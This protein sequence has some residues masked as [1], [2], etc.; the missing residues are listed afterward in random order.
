MLMK[1]LAL[2]T[3]VSIAGTAAGQNSATAPAKP[4]AQPAK[5]DAKV[6]AG[7]KLSEAQVKFEQL[8]KLAGVWQSADDKDGQHTSAIYRVT[9][10]G[11]VVTE[12]LMPGTAHEMI[13]VYTLDGDSILMTHYCAVGNAPRMQSKG[14]GTSNVLAFDFKDATNLKSDKDG[15]MHSLVLTFKDDDHLA[16]AW[17]YYVDGK[18][19]ADHATVFEMKRVKD[20]DAATKILTAAATASCCTKDGAACCESGVKP[21]EK[22]KN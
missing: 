14:G 16:A 9:G 6:V 10:N 11:S 18:P 19:S 1:I 8:K 4:A 2:S 15:H 20:V 12:T 21:A 5:T 7:V 13:S 17:Q 22:A 3:V